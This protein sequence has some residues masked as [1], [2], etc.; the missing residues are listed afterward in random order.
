MGTVMFTLAVG[1]PPHGASGLG[2][3]IIA[4]KP[5]VVPRHRMELL[6]DRV[7]IAAQRMIMALLSQRVDL[8]RRN[9]DKIRAAI[10]ASRLWFAGLP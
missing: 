5:A 3:K 8:R 9:V 4:S 6:R 1:E 10:R 7:S 2:H